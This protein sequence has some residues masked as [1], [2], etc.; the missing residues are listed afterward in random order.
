[1]A[2]DDVRFRVA[3]AVATRARD[4]RRRDAL[5]GIACAW[6]IVMAPAT[7]YV[8]GNQYAPLGESVYAY[9]TGAHSVMWYAAHPHQRRDVERFCDKHGSRPFTHQGDCRNIAR[10]RADEMAARGAR[11]ELAQWPLRK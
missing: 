11:E 5:V 9:V 7:W 6:L 3:V 4:H 2:V 10:L 1:M 8:S